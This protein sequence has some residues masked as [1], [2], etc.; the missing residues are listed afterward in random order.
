MELSPSPCTLY[1]FCLWRSF[2]KCFGFAA[3]V[4]H[5]ST[6]WY[7]G[8][9]DT[10]LSGIP[11]RWPPRADFDFVHIHSPFLWSHFSLHQH[12]T[13]RTIPTVVLRRHW[14]PDTLKS[15]STHMEDAPARIRSRNDPT[16]ISFTTNSYTSIC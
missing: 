12:G 13:T 3:V 6:Q 4:T 2:Q 11:F 9:I 5:Y 15:R 10:A 1:F 7:S 14:R 8:I 16:T